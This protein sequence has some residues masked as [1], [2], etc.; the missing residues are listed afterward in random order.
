MLHELFFIFIMNCFFIFIMNTLN[1]LLLEFEQIP[2]TI[3]SI[4]H[5]ESYIFNV[6]HIILLS[7]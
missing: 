5:H 7:K 1:N 4:L 3:M 6:F 2:I